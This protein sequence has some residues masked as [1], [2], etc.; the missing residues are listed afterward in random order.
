MRRLPILLFLLAVATSL[1][2]QAPEPSQASISTTPVATPALLPPPPVLV[3]VEM[4]K[5]KIVAGNTNHGTVTIDH[6]VNYDLNVSLTFD[7]APMV[8]IEDHVVI[9]HGATSAAFSVFTSPSPETD[10]PVVIH[11]TLYANYNTTKSAPIAI[12]PTTPPTCDGHNADYCTNVICYACFFNEPGIPKDF[13]EKI[14]TY[15]TADPLVEADKDFIVWRATSKPDCDALESYRKDVEKET[16]PDRKLQAYAVLG[17]TARECDGRSATSTPN[18]LRT[19]GMDFKKAAVAAAPKRKAEAAAFQS[20]STGQ[21]KPEFGDVKIITDLSPV[22]GAVTMVLGESTI[23][24]TDDM[25]IGTQIDRVFRDWVSEKLDWSAVVK[26]AK[27]ASIIQ[28]GEGATVD[29]IMKLVPDIQV[30]PLTGTLIA[31]RGG[32]WYGPDEKGVFRFN[33]LDDKVQY[34]TTHVDGNV[35]WI[36]DTHGTSALV[37]QALEYNMQTVIACGDSIGKAKAAFYLA[38]K[39]VNVINMADRYEYLLLGYEGKGTIIGNAPVH[40]VDGTPVVGHQPITFKL[41]EPFVIENTKADYPMQYYDA[42]ARYF[43]RLSSMIPLQVSYVE[44]TAPSQLDKI[45]DAAEKVGSTAIGVRIATEEE[46][47]A[48]RVWLHANP[49]RRAILFHSG[50]YAYAQ[51]LFAD[52]PTQV[53]FGDLRPRFER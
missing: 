45:F 20:L 42:P 9:T 33:V 5:P 44:V 8:T 17:F 48:L 4:D 16:D 37:S 7:P 11:G 32:E 1:F 43:H 24:L 15:P 52:F 30:F 18:A 50:L 3:A 25:R 28:W 6:A 40:V 22:N 14:K 29:A 12:L 47:A 39:G 53:T 38:Q 2:A 34:P 36:I 49:K 35:G 13:V 10:V 41:S 19:L 46:D 21:F 51:G 23:E 27:R 26:P 31:R